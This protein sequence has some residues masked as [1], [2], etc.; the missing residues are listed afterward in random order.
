M[1]AL[2]V[3]LDGV[4]KRYDAG[5]GD[6]IAALDRVDLTVDAGEVV[7]IQGPSGSGKST[8]L[9]VIGAMDRPDSGQVLVGDRDVTRLDDRGQTSYRRTIGFVFQQFYLLPPLTLVDNVT[10]PVL[11][12]A[13]GFDKHQR[14]LE[15]LDA[16]GLKDRA[17]TTPTRLSGGQQQRV[18]IARALVNRPGLVLAD[19]PTGNLDSHTGEAIVTLLLDLRDRFGATI[20]IATHDNAVA[21]R[22]DRTVTIH[23]G[24]TTD[25]TAEP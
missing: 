24:Q 13:T 9:H 8:L 15:L 21:P 23:D 19:E 3:D 11:P 18:A 10:V 5:D 22:C 20:M 4:S 17:D 25:P 6:T 16:V 2:P 1:P 14:A 7:A 12:Y